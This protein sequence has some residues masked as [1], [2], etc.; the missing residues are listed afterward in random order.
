MYSAERGL[1]GRGRG[2]RRPAGSRPRGPGEKRCC[3]REERRG[4]E[5]GDLGVSWAEREL[6]NDS[7]VFGVTRCLAILFNQK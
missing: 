1:S 7:Y 4:R 3:G 5:T 2:E 6:G